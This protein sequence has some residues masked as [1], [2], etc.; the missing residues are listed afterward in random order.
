MTEGEKYAK[1]VED[2]LAKF[3]PL[4]YKVNDARLF[5]LMDAVSV[6]RVWPVAAKEEKPTLKGYAHLISEQVMHLQGIVDTFL[7]TTDKMEYI[8]KLIKELEKTP[9]IFAK[10]IDFI[11]SR[12]YDGTASINVQDLHM[13]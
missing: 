8:G 10:Y 1:I 12:G 2:G 11:K 13:N 7:T 6:A 3:E 5:A 9:H 4:F